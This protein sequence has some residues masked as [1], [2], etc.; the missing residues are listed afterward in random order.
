MKGRCQ[1]QAPPVATLKHDLLYHG[2][3]LIAH[4]RGCEGDGGKVRGWDRTSEEGGSVS[5]LHDV[6]SFCL[7]VKAFASVLVT[8]VPRGTFTHEH[9]PDR[10]KT[11]CVLTHPDEDFTLRPRRPPDCPVVVPAA[12]SRGQGLT[13][14][15][16]S[17]AASFAHMTHDHPCEQFISVLEGAPENGPLQPIL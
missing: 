8:A 7:E 13:A 16:V 3:S 15:C 17:A 5:H 1:H 2:M 12:L 6:P 10:A 4:A 11:R 9:R 14:S